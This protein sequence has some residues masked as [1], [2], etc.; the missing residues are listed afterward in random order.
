MHA[1]HAH[2]GLSRCAQ[3]LAHLAAVS[4]TKVKK[5]SKEWKEGI[6]QQARDYLDECVLM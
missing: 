4:L 1:C 2:Y 3:R 5:K 6:I